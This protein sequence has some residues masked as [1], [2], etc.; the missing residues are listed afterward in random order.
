M[1]RS[2]RLRIVLFAAVDLSLPQGHAL[3]L[4]GLLD[5]LVDRGHAVVLLT[6]RPAGPRP[7]TRFERI[8]IPILRWRVLGLWSFEL[9]A[10]LC[11]TFL[12][13]RRRP[14][15]IVAR[16]DLYTVAPAIVSRVLRLP[17]VSQVNASIPEEL[18][19][20]GRMRAQRLAAFCE[21]LHLRNARAVLVLAESHGRALAARVGI[22]P[23]R[24]RT[25]AIGGR[26]PD[27]FDAAKTRGDLGVPPETFLVGY[28]G[29]LA[30]IQGVD[31]LLAAF[32]D[33]GE[34]DARLWIVGTGTDEGRLEQAAAPLGSRV[35]FF[36]GVEPGVVDQLMGAC[37]ILIAPYRRADYERVSGGGALSSKIISYL[38]SDRPILVTGMASY[39]WIEE[40]GAGECFDSED[41]A[42]LSG[43]IRAW[44]SRW[45]DA[46]SPLVD[47]PWEAPGPGRR[48][49]AQERSWERVAERVETVL[50]AVSS[51]GRRER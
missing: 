8:E 35:R 18:A 32:V 36:G 43:A 26:L 42:G 37:Q 41:P 21:R 14:D 15:L 33:L 19:I 24:I 45:V 29:N 23:A 49:V 30:P 13:L 31:L 2:G 7:V 12:C 40:I 27:R 5:A 17:L 44:R 25:I 6:P 3:H 48:Y 50:A 22:D 1:N 34:V 28:A 4:R 16:H 38:A 39:R 46:G 11:L 20:M 10:G 9:I 47:W 51:E